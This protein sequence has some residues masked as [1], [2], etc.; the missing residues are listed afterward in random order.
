MIIAKTWI[1][2]RDINE[3]A[4]LKTSYHM[5]K[6]MVENFYIG[7]KITAQLFPSSYLSI[8]FLSKNDVLMQ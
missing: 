7:K 8:F 4:E 5:C 6:I 1:P 3:V 2:R